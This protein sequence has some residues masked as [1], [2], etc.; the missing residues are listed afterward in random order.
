MTRLEFLLAI[1]IV[2][3]IGVISMLVSTLTGG[4][5]NVILVPFLI[6]IYHFPAGE[7]IGTAFLALLAGSIIAALGF[8]AKGQAKV[9]LGILLGLLTVPGILLGTL[10]SAIT[11]EELFR[12]SLGIVILAL[13]FLVAKG[14]HG[15]KDNLSSDVQQHVTNLPNLKLASVL[16]VATGFFIGF[17][18]QGGGLLLLPVMQFAG[19]SFL[20]TLGTL[21]IIAMIISA[22]A[23]SSRLAIAQ[24]NLTIG[25]FLA[26]GTIAGGFLGARIATSA[27]ITL[28]KY[29]AAALIASLG[30]A[31]IVET[32]A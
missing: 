22:T 15:E 10:L 13:S 27:N 18:G 6:L 24:V 14:R 28:L 11:Q 19:F 30:V 8:I 7:A 16:F 20:Q 29:L 23:F 4:G 31:L 17:F 25:V 2:F 1:A 12:L 9:R 21:R 5:T 26:L 3:L 32:V